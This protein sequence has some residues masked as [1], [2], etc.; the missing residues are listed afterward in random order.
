MT[1]HRLVPNLDRIIVHPTDSPSLHPRTPDHRTKVK[2][3]HIVQSARRIRDE[4]GGA[5]PRTLE[6]L[7]TMAG[8]GPTLAPLLVFLFQYREQKQQASAK[9]EA[10]QGVGKE[11]ADT[12]NKAPVEVVVLDDTPQKPAGPLVEEVAAEKA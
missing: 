4:L 10:R 9:D 11:G 1:P 2:S 6:G 3:K 7:L 12:E 5:V 8:I